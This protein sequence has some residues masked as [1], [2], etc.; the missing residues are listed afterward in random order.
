MSLI[1]NI[2]K[3]LLINT[4]V[5][6]FL[7]IFLETLLY[8]TRIVI[9]RPTVGWIIPTKE[10]RA[11]EDP[12]ENKETHPILSHVHNHQ[13][14][15]KLL[16][17]QTIGEYIYYDDTIDIKNKKIIVALGGSTTDGF[18]KHYSN[19]NTW[20]K[21][22]NDLLKKNNYNDWIIINGGV[23]AY[24][25]SQE[26]LKLI[27]STLILDKEIKIVIS[28]NGI[29]E[30]PN[31]FG[32]NEFLNK[33]FP[34]F[35]RSQA[36]MI[37]EKKWLLQSKQYFPY[38]PN[39]N[40][41]IKYIFGNSD[42]QISQRLKNKFDDGSFVNIYNEG[43]NIE[44]VIDRYA[45]NLSIMDAV[46]KVNEVKFYS[47]LQPTMGLNGIQNKA[48]INTNDYKILNKISDDYKL[49]LNELY[50]KLRLAC[51]K[52]S[53]C[54]DITEIA[55]PDGDNYYDERHH[56]QNGNVIIASEIFKQIKNNLN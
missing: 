40:S 2:S 3:I 17:G 45:Y 19:G 9:D 31:Y 7:I 53:Y 51:N 18:Y 6:I 21:L 25:T 5:L 46:S 16:H 43:S 39:I 50:D 56:N 44:S 24:N 1:N 36:Y 48:P 15:C 55:N 20:P 54:Y 23:G 33:N 37:Q 13:N 32:T 26:A 10:M 34:F 52:K 30:F 12:C 38:F 47:F 42:Y 27:T 14:K 4:L 29:N 35:T 49:E 41:L 8:V 28:L 22:L 11:I